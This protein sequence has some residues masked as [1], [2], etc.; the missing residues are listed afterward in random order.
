[1]EINKELIENY[2]LTED[3][4]KDLT[5]A[6]SAKIAEE[7]NL[8]ASKANE[9]AEGIL[10]GAIKSIQDEY[11]IQIERKQGEKVRDWATRAFPEVLKTKL[12]SKEAELDTLKSEYEKKVGEA[13]KED[14]NAIKAQYQ[15]EK[16]DL[17]KRY[18]GFDE[19]KTK[20]EKA[21]EYEKELVSL[22]KNVAYGKIKPSF[23]DTVNKY[24][25][26][27]KWGD[28]IKRLESDYDL[29]FADDGEPLYISKENP[30][31]KGSLKDLVAKD[32]QIQELVKGRQQT[33]L[34]DKKGAKQFDGIPFKIVEGEDIGSQVRDYL[35]VQKKL[36]IT[37]KEYSD[38]FRRLVKEIKQKTAA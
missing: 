13:S 38:E 19:I 34:G 4:V 35:S 12:K 3:A 8:F 24:E 26:D 25:V 16:D 32:S 11:G 23:P 22:R 1:M 7:K 14:I 27:A 18:A 9:D 6:L 20:S 31:N 33:G 2:N 28:F 36:S 17:L 30:H 21:D 10:S 29:G 15:A 5:D 37:S